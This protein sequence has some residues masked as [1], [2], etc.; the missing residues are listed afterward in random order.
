MKKVL[1]YLRIPFALALLVPVVSC[2][3]SWKISDA[4]APYL[5]SDIEKVTPV[6]TGLLLG[7][8]KYFKEKRLNLYFLHRIDAAVELYRAKKIKYIIV[9]GNSRP[10]K[11]E[12]QDMREELIRRGVPS[13]VIFIDYAG[14]RTLD[15]VLRAKD[16]FVQE[17]FLIISQKFHNER[18]VFIARKN[19]INAHGYNAGE[20]NALSIQIREFFARDK[21]FLDMLTGVTAEVSGKKVM[22]D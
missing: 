3:L 19:G 7:T 20:V 21:V 17:S 5:T 15:S 6:K 4:S 1:R 18:A 13:S 12:A 22:I 10:P 2:V 11:R 16:V 8:N 14:Y 9:S